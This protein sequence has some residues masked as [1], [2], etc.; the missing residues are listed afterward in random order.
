MLIIQP[1]FYAIAPKQSGVGRRIFKSMKVGNSQIRDHR[2]ASENKDDFILP[3]LRS[4]MDNFKLLRWTYRLL[5]ITGAEIRGWMDTDK[6]LLE[7]A[8]ISSIEII[9]ILLYG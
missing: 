6:F 7:I 5:F 2:I 4:Q 9:V 1:S 3:R 8:Y